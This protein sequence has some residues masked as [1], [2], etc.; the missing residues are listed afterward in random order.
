MKQFSHSK[1]ST[2]ERCPLHFKFRYLTSLK[3]VI[4]NTIEAFTGGE[5]HK[6]FE[7]LYRD[8]LKAKK[9]SLEDLLEF[10]RKEWEANWDDTIAIDHQ[11]YDQEHWFEVGRRCIKNYYEQYHPFD[12]DQTVGVEKKLSLQWGDYTITGVIDR[13]SR[14]KRGVY[15][16]HDYK[17]NQTITEQK[18]ADN[19]RQLALYSMWV[20]ENFKEAKEV[21]LIWHFVRFGED[22]ESKRS[23]KEL[24]Q[25][26]S[27]ILE[28][29]ADINRAEAEDDFPARENKC[30]WCGFWQHCPKKKHLF[31]VEKL[32][33]NKYLK[34][35]GVKLAKKYI[36]LATKRSKINKNARTD[37]IVIVIEEEMEKVKE[38]I[39][40]YAKKHSVETLHGDSHLVIIKRTEQSSFPTKSG[41]PEGYDKLECLLISTK[42][43]KDVSSINST[44]LN[45]ALESGEIDEETKNKI[46]EIAPIEEDVSISI[47]KNKE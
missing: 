15:A 1:L 33:Q 4:K 29:I 17:T 30:E 2:Y 9:N 43:W 46:L 36:E 13:L 23:D 28:V 32:P 37:V 38:A 44:K 5:V 41:D 40:V 11:E 31:K 16:V 26:K 21:K 10:F 20:K 47:R 35:D 18:Y 42:Y 39:L 22:I 25:L 27:G 45:Q 14:E 3:P 12:Q 8:L 24:G 6:V 19:D 7:V 34:D